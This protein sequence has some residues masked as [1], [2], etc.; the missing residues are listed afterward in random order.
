[1]M[2]PQQRA[3]TVVIVVRELG[4]PRDPYVSVDHEVTEANIAAA[5]RA[6]EADQT[7]RC[8]AAAIEA[9]KHHYGYSGEIVAADVRRAVRSA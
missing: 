3:E 7:E 4:D 5:I 9:I 8:V 6:A 1:M 2:T